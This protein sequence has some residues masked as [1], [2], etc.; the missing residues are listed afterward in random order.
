MALIFN[1][2]PNW[3]APPTKDWV[4][5]PGWQPDP[6][7]GEAPEGWNF[8][9]EEND[10]AS[11]HQSHADEADRT[12]VL[13]PESEKD[14]AGTNPYAAV[15]EAMRQTLP[16]DQQ[17]SPTND[18]AVGSI[19]AGAVGEK[20][21]DAETVPL[22]APAQPGFTGTYP[23]SSTGA[24]PNSGGPAGPGAYSDTASY[25][26]QSAGEQPKSKTGLII[27]VIGGILLLL[28]AL[29][30]GL[31]F[32][33]GGIANNASSSDSS[34]SWGSDSGSS[35]FN[36]SS[37]S[38]KSSDTSNSGS[39]DAPVYSGSGDS[40]FD[41]EK[42]GGADG[43]AWLEYTFTGEDKYAS[44]SISS[45]DAD[46][47]TNL[48]V[49]DSLFEPEG[50]GSYWLDASLFDA[51]DRTTQLK[52]EAKGDWT[53]TLHTPD[54]APTLESGDTLQGE[55]ATAFR[56]DEG[57]EVTADISFTATDQ[58]GGSL[59]VKTSAGAEDDY[60]EVVLMTT[61]SDFKGS[62]TF[63]AG[64]QYVSVEPDSG[65]WEIKAY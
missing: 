62:A 34:D 54:K 35:S 37:G 32:I 63:P 51:E 20:T 29:V 1:P 50:S 38:G 52:I 56:I 44:F 3:P 27:G 24:Y 17:P 18:E 28:L 14:S 13:S 33:I 65:S 25:N 39:A 2:P 21:D 11:S 7:W 61:L 31:F 64:K 16:E 53:V 8:W 43:L 36:D 23:G 58:Y 46:G 19:R 26:G 22:G 55:N 10:L 12:E 9:V 45:L 42:P 4:P 59:K 41:I 47:E 40:T 30:V 5:Q 57:A 6:S 15:S 49:H 48:A 60:D